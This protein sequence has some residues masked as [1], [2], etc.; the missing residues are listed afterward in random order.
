[1]HGQVAS[2]TVDYG[3]ISQTKHFHWW[4][5]TIFT[6]LFP[7]T[8]RS[9]VRSPVILV[10]HYVYDKFYTKSEVS[11]A[12]LLRAIARDRRTDRR[13]PWGGPHN[14]IYFLFASRVAQV[15]KSQ[16]VAGIA[17]RTASRRLWLE[18][19]GSLSLTGE[20][21]QFHSRLF[22]GPLDIIYRVGQIKWHH[23]TFL[24]VTN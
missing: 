6:F 17:D 15:T 16:A 12:F 22:G 4:N 23:F 5:E 10:Q 24:F 1:M 11:K 7:V 21:T 20:L 13:V 18:R 19:N 3:Q 2:T 8:F 14:N 9:Q